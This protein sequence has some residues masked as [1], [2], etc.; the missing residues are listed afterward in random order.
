MLPEVRLELVDLEVGG[1]DTPGDGERA[2]RTGGLARGEAGRDLL[3]RV[4]YPVVDGDA[5]PGDEDVVEPREEEGAVGD[6]VHRAV[7]R[8][9]TGEGDGVREG[10]VHLLT[11]EDVTAEGAPR[12][13]DAEHRGGLGDVGAFEAGHLRP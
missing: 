3:R 9:V 8:P 11:G 6:G 1:L 4:V 2:R 7:L 5:S 13:G 12:F 10:P